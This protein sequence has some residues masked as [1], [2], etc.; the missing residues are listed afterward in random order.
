M[1]LEGPVPSSSKN[2]IVVKRSAVGSGED[3]EVDAISSKCLN[4][5]DGAGQG[6][7]KWSDRKTASASRYLPHAVERIRK[8]NN[9]MVQHVVGNG[10]HIPSPIQTFGEALPIVQRQWKQCEKL[11]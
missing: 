9:I 3:S 6:R 11:N 4:D 8:D 1:S 7:P 10:G 5:E 2:P